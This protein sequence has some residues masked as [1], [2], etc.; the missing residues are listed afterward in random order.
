VISGRSPRHA[1]LEDLDPGRSLFAIHSANPTG[2]FP[3]QRHVLAV[4]NA[5]QHEMENYS[6]G[7][8]Q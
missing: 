4:F 2:P 7:G 6:S 3:Q 1:L 5:I 8:S